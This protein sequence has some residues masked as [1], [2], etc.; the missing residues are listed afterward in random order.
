VPQDL[1]HPDAAAPRRTAARAPSRAP[2]R[3][4]LAA[5]LLALVVPSSRAKGPEPILDCEARGRARPICGFQ[6][7]EDLVSLPGAQA[8]IVS[9]YGDVEG[10]RPG[11]LVLFALA[12]DERRILFEGGRPPARPRRD[13]GDPRCPEPPGQAFSPHGIDLVRRDDGALQ[14]LVVQHGDREAIELFEAVGSGTNWHLTWRGCVPAPE[15]AS[16]NDVVGLSDGRFYTTKMMS[17][18]DDVEAIFEK[19]TATTGRVFAW[20]PGQ[21]YAQIPGT[22][23]R[24]PNGLAASTDGRIVYVNLSGENAIRK[25]EVESGRELG[26]AEVASPDNVTWTPDGRRLL[27]ASLS[28]SNPGEFERCRTLE[29]GACAIP[30]SIVAIDPETMRVEGP[31]YT[32][33]GAPMGAGTVGLQVGHE[34]FVGSF[35]GDRILRVELGAP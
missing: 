29:R 3:I 21:G 8:L 15:K 31:V 35:A 33:E 4:A 2:V 24:M 6:N 23:G 25:V 11:R 16:L 13:W 28:A 18:G 27:V 19:P 14:L 20:T 9:E 30:F 17:L 26:R 34:L 5:L 12:T 22:A 10:G 7:P 1:V 32:S